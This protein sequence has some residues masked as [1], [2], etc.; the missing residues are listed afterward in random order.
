MDDINQWVPSRVL[1]YFYG[2][3]LSI[4]AIQ[5]VEA[6]DH[7][8]ADLIFDETTSSNN[9]ENVPPR[10]AKYKERVYSIIHGGYNLY[11]DSK[12]NPTGTEID[13]VLV[14]SKIVFDEK[15]VLLTDHTDS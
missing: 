7:L 15:Y 13:G 6:I 5:S 2:T 11:M 4:D 10:L 14:R 8:P 9:A 12:S 1:K 3:L